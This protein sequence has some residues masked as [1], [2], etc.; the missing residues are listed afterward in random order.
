MTI[1][2]DKKDELVYLWR[3]HGIKLVA[4]I[5]YLMVLA[6]IAPRF[7]PSAVTHCADLVRL[8]E[9]SVTEAVISG[10]PESKESFFCFNGVRYASTA[11]DRWIS[12]D[13]LMTVEGARYEDNPFSF[14]A[15]L[16][17]GTCAVSENI[18]K[19]ERLKLG[20]KLSVR[21]T[22]H[23]FEIAEIIP[24]QGGI[25]ATYGHEGV[26]ILS[27][28]SELA[29]QAESFMSM[30]VNGDQYT[31]YD[32]SVYIDDMMRSATAKSVALLIALVAVSVLTAA[33]CEAS[34]ERRRYNDY[35]LMFADGLGPGALY[36]FIVKELSFK[37][38]VPTALIVFTYLL[39][40]GFYKAGCYWVLGAYFVII[41]SL[42]LLSAKIICRGIFVCRVKKINAKQ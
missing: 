16:T 38:L 30:T 1:N 11:D 14:C 35:K 39:K 28:A 9:T 2:K 20:D 33:A 7:I 36:T 41:V 13:L 25:D 29:E 31:N 27:Y 40:M 23:E 8:N 42:L 22:D 6:V 24:A 26:V 3:R 4:I 21:K 37:Y 12:C 5:V 15:D 18:M 34:L 32:R 19:R 10:I 17:E